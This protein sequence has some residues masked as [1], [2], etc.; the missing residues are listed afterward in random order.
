MTEAD[1]IQIEQYIQGSLSTEEMAAF[2]QRLSSDSALA[3]AYENSLAAHALIKEAGRME[4][5]ETLES[6]EKKKGATKVR[7]LNKR[8]TSLIAATLLLCLGMYFMSDYFGS[9]T[10][11]QVYESYFEMY[12][13]PSTLRGDAPDETPYWDTAVAAY[14]NENYQEALTNFERAESTIPNDKVAFYKSLCQLQLDDK[15][16]NTTLHSL[17]KISN[18]TSDYREQAL[19]YYALGSLKNGNKQEALHAFERIVKNKSYRYE[20]A[21]EII[22]IQFK[23]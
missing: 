11:E 12:A 3:E 18:G 2:K 14:S 8:R 6:F 4:L 19:W 16:L 9:K 21:S 10:P 13:A 17:Q 5:K 23:D 22:K 15:Y 1:E 7:Y 20:D